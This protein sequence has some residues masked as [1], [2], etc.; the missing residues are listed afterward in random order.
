VVIVQHDPVQQLGPIGI[1]ALGR[2]AGHE[3][4]GQRGAQEHGSE[5]PTLEQFDGSHAG[6]T[7]ATDHEKGQRRNEQ[8]AGQQQEKPAQA[9][10]FGGGT[11]DQ[12]PLAHPF[13]GFAIEQGIHQLGGAPGQRDEGRA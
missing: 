7:E 8:H 1:V 3:Q 2:E 12:F 11:G 4:E 9:P 13:V 5:V 10:H 6:H